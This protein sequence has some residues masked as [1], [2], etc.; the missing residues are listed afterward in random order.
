MAKQIGVL[1]IEGT[2]GNLTF[3]RIGNQYFVRLKSSLSGRRVKTK[4][5]FERTMESAG[6]MARGSSLGS[7]VYRTLRITRNRA[8]Y[9]RITGDAILL[10]K[11]GI[12]WNEAETVLMNKYQQKEKQVIRKEASAEKKMHKAFQRAKE[13]PGNLQY[14]LMNDVW[15]LTTI[16]S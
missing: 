6:R 3:Y 8:L 1:K 16:R 12:T 10:F 13:T 11:Q 5:E 9:Q 14:E 15:V 4:P 7:K 2:I